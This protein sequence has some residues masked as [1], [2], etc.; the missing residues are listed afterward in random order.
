MIHKSLFRNV[1]VRN[2]RVLADE[3]LR[4]RSV[5]EN[6]RERA[7][8]CVFYELQWHLFVYRTACFKSACFNMFVIYIAACV[9]VYNIHAPHV[10]YRNILTLPCINQPNIIVTKITRFR[11]Y[12]VA[13]RARYNYR[14]YFDSLYL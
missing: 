9:R 6:K 11:R 4:E 13:G 1:S 14:K 2:C 7:A 3:T 10:L 12:F 8:A 5:I